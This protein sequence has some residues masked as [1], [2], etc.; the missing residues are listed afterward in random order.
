MSALIA[1]VAGPLAMWEEV[2]RNQQ[3]LHDHGVVISHD[4]TSGAEDYITSGKS[5]EQNFEIA[6]RCIEG[7]A[8]ADVVLV[9]ISSYLPSQGLWVEIGAALALG[10]RVIAMVP[11]AGTLVMQGSSKEYRDKLT[12]ER[13]LA[14]RQRAAFLDHP[15]V[16]VTG[17]HLAVVKEIEALKKIKREKETK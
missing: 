17:S 4:W 5:T 6:T 10:K 12:V 7:V 13:F 11:E 2:Q 9:L 8:V 3:W 1:Y 15:L 14:W 16:M